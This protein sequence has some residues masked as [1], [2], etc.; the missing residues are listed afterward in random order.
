[1]NLEGSIARGSRALA[2]A[3]VLHA[4][5]ALAND[6][7]GR[8]ILDVCVALLRSGARTIVASRG[9]PLVGELQAL[10]G[11]W[12]DYDIVGASLFK[13]RKMVRNLRELVLG[14]RVDLVHAHGADIARAMSSIVGKQK[15]VAF[16]TTYLSLRGGARWL[17]PADM[18]P[19]GV[20]I[21]PSEYAADVVAEQH[22]M[23]RERIVVLPRPVDTNV[24]DPRRI[25]PGRIWFLRKAWRVG[26][27]ERVVLAPG[28]LSRDQGYA[29]LIE[30]VRIL[31]T[32]GLRRT[33]FVIAADRETDV[34]FGVELDAQ[35]AVHGLTRVMRR[36]GRCEDMPAAHAMA[37][38][39]VL[40]P[41]RTTGF[42]TM[43]AEAQAMAR[44]LI[45]SHVGALPGLIEPATGEA[46][47][48]KGW[49]V[50]PGAPMQLA[51]TLAEALAIDRTVWRELSA[52]ARYAAEAKFA[53][54]RVAAATLALYG[55]LLQAEPN[56][57]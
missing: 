43:A 40:V 4:A 31:L 18:P 53:R 42:A 29:T 45:A 5:P 56:A 27:E 20:A 55:D 1:V 28:R 8:A 39:V 25:D 19:H 32:G 49:L 34:E 2:G 35:I 52:R 48:R 10:G 51:K 44:P 15:R 57:A 24:F 16:V 21:A 54:S 37:D 12:L 33:V 23:A 50:E 9:G 6:R 38:F 11:E 22:R 41:E 14:E 26:P 7:L 46:E 3:T 17:G 30:A 47:E 36:I 13:R